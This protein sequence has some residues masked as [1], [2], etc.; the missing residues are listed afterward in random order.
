MRFLHH[1]NVK[2]EKPLT[3]EKL[4]RKRQSVMGNENSVNAQ[5]T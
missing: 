2:L 5:R 4:G 1:Y 3:K